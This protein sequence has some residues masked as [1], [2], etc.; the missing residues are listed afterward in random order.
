V[1]LDGVEIA[2]D[3]IVAEH[4]T[5]LHRAPGLGSGRLTVAYEAVLAGRAPPPPV[6]ELDVIRYRRP[7]RYCESDRIAAYARN[8]FRGLR[9]RALLDA[10]SSWVGRR[11]AYVAESSRP[12]DSAVSTLLAREGVCRDFAHLVIAMLRAC[13]TPA[14]FVSVYAPGLTPMDFH[15][16]VEAHVDGEW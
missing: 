15:A 7:S 2:L 3:E 14:R 1:T 4:G 10:V 16:V 12:I 13:D 6:V 11:V 8:E 5:R 9:G